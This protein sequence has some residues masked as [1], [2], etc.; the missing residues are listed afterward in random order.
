MRN[1]VWVSSARNTGQYSKRLSYDLLETDETAALEIL[2]QYERGMGVAEQDLPKRLYDTKGRPDDAPAEGHLGH[3]IISDYIV[4]SDHVANVLT[5]MD[6][7]DGGLHPLEGIFAGDRKTKLPG[8]Y[9]ILD[10]GARKPVFSPEESRSDRIRQVADGIPLWNIYALDTGDDEIA[11]TKEALVGADI[12]IDPTAPQQYFFSRR[13]HDA[14]V[15]NGYQ[16][17]F[18]P[19]RCLVV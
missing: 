1:V 9:S 14:L 6:F 11:V 12:W 4:L 13:F 2:K 19:K 16:T 3:L 10:I 5:E 18:S 8:D 7:G 15:R 17:L